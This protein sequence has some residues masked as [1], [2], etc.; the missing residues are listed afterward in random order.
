[1]VSIMDERVSLETFSHQPETIAPPADDVLHAIPEP[2][3][4]GAS[5]RGDIPGTGY[6]SHTMRPENSGTNEEVGPPRFSWS[7][8]CPSTADTLGSP[9]AIAATARRD[10]ATPPGRTSRTTSRSARHHQRQPRRRAASAPAQLIMPWTGVRRSSAPAR[11]CS[12]VA[13]G[14]RSSARRRRSS[15][16]WPRR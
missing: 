4:I 16:W 7:A 15:P 10:A 12:S 5:V 6:S 3:D 2:S 11:T 13:N 1:M 14:R 8:A 9:D